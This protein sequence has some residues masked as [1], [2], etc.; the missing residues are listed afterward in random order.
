L[1]SDLPENRKASVHH[2]EHVILLVGGW[3]I[4]WFF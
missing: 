2:F 1:V 3:N 4:L